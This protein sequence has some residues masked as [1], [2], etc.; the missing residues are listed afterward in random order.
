MALLEESEARLVFRETITFASEIQCVDHGFVELTDQSENELVFR[1]YYADSNNEQGT[2][3][4]IGSV[5]KIQ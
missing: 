4:A 3:G 2:L 5:A 1:W